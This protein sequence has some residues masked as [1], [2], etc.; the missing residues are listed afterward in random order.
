MGMQGGGKP[1]HI[2]GH[3]YSLLTKIVGVFGSGLPALLFPSSIER[4]TYKRED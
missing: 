3:I 1:F 2:L 4:R